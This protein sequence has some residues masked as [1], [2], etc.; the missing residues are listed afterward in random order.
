MQ[1]DVKNLIRFTLLLSQEI[2]LF[3]RKR[4]ALDVWF[5]VATRGYPFKFQAHYFLKTE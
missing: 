2:I 3:I 1:S 5:E 4:Y